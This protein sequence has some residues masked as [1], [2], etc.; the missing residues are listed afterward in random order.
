MPQLDIMTFK[1]Q[2][3]SILFI[4]FF[5]YLYFYINILHN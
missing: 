2:G 3:L 4:F 1:L 5:L